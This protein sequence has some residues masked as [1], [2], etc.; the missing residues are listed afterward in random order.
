MQDQLAFA[1]L[2]VSIISAMFTFFALYQNRKINITN[3]EAKHFEE[4]FTEYIVTKIP[5]TVEEIEFTTKGRLQ[6]Y[7]HLIDTLMDMICDCKYYAYAKHD[8]YQKLQ[9][10]C[11]AFEDHI[12][13][14]ANNE[15][16]DA[17]LQAKNIYEI[18]EELV[19][20]I[21]LIN[22]NYHNF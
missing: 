7:S 21:K 17:D 12:L 15:V 18:H 10:E 22:K 14:I 20:I 13:E 4:I 5:E 6:S 3:L 19:K 16:M 11:I 9:R 8:F 2:I 1:A